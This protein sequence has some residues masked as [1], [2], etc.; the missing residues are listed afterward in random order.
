MEGVG[1]LFPSCQSSLDYSKSIRLEED[2]FQYIILCIKDPGVLEIK[3]GSGRNIL[4]QY[5]KLHHHLLFTVIILY[6]FKN[7]SF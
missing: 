4:S 3:K 7:M 5:Q 1:V 2:P 6:L